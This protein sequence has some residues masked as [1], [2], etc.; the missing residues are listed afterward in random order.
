MKFSSVLSMGLMVLIGVSADLVS[1]VK[2]MPDDRVG[3]RSLEELLG[4]TQL[5]PA[6]SVVPMEGMIDPE[7]YVVGPADVVSISLWGPISLTYSLSV[8]PEGTVI[9]PTVGEAKI[10]GRTLVAA[11][12]IVRDMVRKRFV[13]GEISMT[14]M[15][16]RSFVVTLRGAV[17]MPG[18]YVASPVVRVEKIVREGIKIPQPTTTMNVP[19]V[20]RDVVRVPQLDRQDEFSKSSSLRNILLIRKSG[21]TLRI[22]IPKFYSTQEDRY[23]PFLL[24]GDI[25]VVPR[26]D[27]KTDFVSVLGAVNSPGSYEFVPGDRLV[28][29]IG[30]AQGLAP[31]ADS[32]TIVLSRMDDSGRNLSDQTIELK[33]VLRGERENIPLMR[34]D[35]IVVSQVESRKR[36]YQVVVSGEVLFPGRYPISVSNTRLSAVMKKVGGL[37]DHALL[38]G[39]IL[40]RK[41][42]EISE[43]LDPSLQRMRNL[44]AYPGFPGDSAYFLL[45]MQSSYV[46]VVVDF[47]KL[48]NE[49]DSTQ[50]IVLQDE[51]IIFVP[52]D[53]STV[54]VN[55]QVSKPGHIPFVRG[56]RYDYYIRQAGG[57][58]GSALSG[59]VKIIKRATLAWVDPGDTNLEPG[60]QIWVPKGV[61]RD[62]AYYFT[63]LRDAVS[64]TAAV[65]TAVL[66]YI[67]VSK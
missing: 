32:G 67:Q 10:G 25:I 28:D 55:G 33:R 43:D 61:Q 13:M 24:D 35:R 2:Q 42:Q 59:D 4:K 9:I 16:P 37:T 44:R 63:I 62:F 38:T 5:P 56:A 53:L 40:L 22:D 19:S 26:R 50:D 64:V 66:L 27:L 21:D 36:D 14:L 51:D 46:P 45:N 41:E 54:I 11:K 6:T 23:N 58:L 47:H 29:L 65:A 57:F 18:S 34:G 8:T 39:A 20:G 3:Q 49:G 7:T 60:D 48:L 17:L 15:T 30:I 1:Q 12:Q 31:A 52:S